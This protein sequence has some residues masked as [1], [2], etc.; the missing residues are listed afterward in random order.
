MYAIAADVRHEVA[1]LARAPS[2]MDVSA[3]AQKY[4]RVQSSGGGAVPWDPAIT[5]Y[6]VEPMNVL[7]SRHYESV[8]F[9]G[10]ARTGKTQ[11]LVDCFV[12]YMVPCDPSD[13]LIVQISQEKAKDFSKLRINR[14]HRNSPALA[15]YLST[16]KQDDNVHEKYYKAGNVLKIAWP[17]V[18][19]LS[20]SEYKYVVLTDY[21]RMPESLDKEGSAFAL[22]QK[23]TQTYLSRGMTVAESSPGHEVIDPSWKSKKETPHE[24]PPTR[25]ILS[26]FNLG[27][28]RRLYMP[29]PHCGEYFMPLPGIE[30]FSFNLNKDLFGA[31]DTQ[32]TGIVGLIPTCCGVVIEEKHKAEMNAAGLWVPEGCRVTHKRKT[33]V[34][35][36]EARNSKIASFWLPGAAA[37]YQTWTSIVQRYLNAL[38][39]YDLTG[40]EETL[41]TT[42]NVDQGSPYL[43]RRMMAETS[44]E[45][46]ERRAE[47]LP[48]RKVP[49][50]VRFILAKIDVQGTRFVVQVTG[51]GVGY[52]SW[53]I[54]RFDIHISERIRDGEPL[55]L[56][57]AGYIEDWDLIISKV[58]KRSYP[59]ADNSGRTMAILATG[60]DSGGKEGVT[61]RAYSFWR[62]TKKKRLQNRFFLFKG[63]RP[64]RK[65]NKPRV[66]KSYPDNTKRKDRKADARGD[67]PL[68]L[69]NTTL[70]KDSVMADLKRDE[71]G[72]RYMHFPD[73]LG[74]WFYEELLAE[75]R[76]DKGWDNLRRVKNET[77][78]L[79][80]YGKGLIDCY[81]VEKRI[82]QI[83]WDNPPTWAAEWNNNSQI[84]LKV[85]ESTIKRY[86]KRVLSPGVK[87]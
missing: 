9:A 8:I 22:G 79:Y 41:Q 61:D 2:R 34:I 11:A 51:Y 25:G 56:D 45:D 78:D 49:D 73:W 26:L 31:T 28:R 30:A 46:L 16:N 33:P 54:D 77:F 29:C 55:Q 17:T 67:V 82:K 1:A 43:P 76:T 70:L 36:G 83:D 52:E 4:V 53:V 87:L 63:E 19:Q 60:C 35:V 42:T 14:M 18:K 72:P 69:L 23:R 13:M 75:V 81:L 65:A 12:G 44:T 38:R 37:A 24:A 68:W 5:P 64:D 84:D 74:L 80:A 66:S 58:M 47:D 85:E 40:S 21:D 71:P 27:D 62:K 39:E 6:M 57:P 59:L 3:A 7:T 50:G 20:S 86:R 10:P 15:D 32:I 48:K